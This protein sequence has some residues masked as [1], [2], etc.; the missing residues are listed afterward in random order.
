MLNR[1]LE[2]Q[3]IA[4]TLIEKFEFALPP[5]KEENLIRRRPTLLMVPMAEGH[6]GIWMGLKVK[7]AE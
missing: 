5:Q 7:I 6:P 1:L 3:A 4:A 2:M